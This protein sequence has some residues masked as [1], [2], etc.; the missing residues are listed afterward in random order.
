MLTNNLG[1]Y[2]GKILVDLVR[3]IIYFPVWWYSRGLKQLL[4][5][6]K[7]FLTNKEK[8]LVFFVWVKNI[9][10]PMYSQY[11]WAG[12]LISFFVGFFK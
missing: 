12:V 6:L 1:V 10:R 8:S 4:L 5:K 3:D 9:F 7:D 11:D 2:A